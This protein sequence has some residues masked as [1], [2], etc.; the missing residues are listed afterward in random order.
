[1]QKSN[2]LHY[3]MFLYYLRLSVHNAFLVFS[4]SLK[5][6]YFLWIL[7][8]WR[9]ITIIAFIT[10]LCRKSHPNL[11]KPQIFKNCLNTKW[12]RL[13]RKLCC[14]FVPW[15]QHH[16]HALRNDSLLRPGSC[17][18]ALFE[19]TSTF[20]YVIHI[21]GQSVKKQ[22]FVDIKADMKSYIPLETAAIFF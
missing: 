12:S 13:S 5:K 1:M 11:L 4:F 2:D 19:V 10:N 21:V 14:P 6:C 3:L 16:N 20:V 9:M 15:C 7:K 8:Q 17:I 18:F 22:G